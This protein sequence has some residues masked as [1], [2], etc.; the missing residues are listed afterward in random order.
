MTRTLYSPYR[1]VLSCATPHT[2]GV[3][4]VLEFDVT[5]GQADRGPH[6]MMRGPCTA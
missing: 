2:C 1:A 5:A 6:A 3:V 4:I